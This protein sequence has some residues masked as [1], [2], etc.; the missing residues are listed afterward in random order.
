MNGLKLSDVAIGQIVQLLQMGILT[1]TD[2][3]DQIRTLR[4]DVDSSTGHLVPS[5]EFL[6]TFG[7]NLKRLEELA[8]QEVTVEEE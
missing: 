1:G 8:A 6:E 3:S 5:Q 7:E 2:I 4:L